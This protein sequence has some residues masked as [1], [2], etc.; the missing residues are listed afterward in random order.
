MPT[1]CSCIHLHELHASKGFWTSDSEEVTCLQRSFG[2]CFSAPKKSSCAEI[3]D[4][5]GVAFRR[6]QRM[7]APRN[8]RRSRQM[9]WWT[10]KIECWKKGCYLKIDINTIFFSAAPGFSLALPKSWESI[11]S[12]LHGFPGVHLQC[13][14]DTYK[15]NPQTTTSS[16]S[17]SID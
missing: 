10:R 13:A 4:V 6:H 1:Y 14:L 2:R 5:C 7:Q 11:A 9:E 8:V 12:H 16:Q 3:H 15:L 17:T